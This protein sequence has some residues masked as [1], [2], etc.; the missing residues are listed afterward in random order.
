MVARVW[1]ISREESSRLFQASALVYATQPSS[2]QMGPA[3]FSQQ[4][5]K[6]GHTLRRIGAALRFMAVCG[7]LVGALAGWPTAS[8][9]TE[10]PADSS[11]EHRH[12]GR[13]G[14]D[15]GRAPRRRG[16]DPE[17]GHVGHPR[18]TVHGDG[19]RRPLPILAA[20]PAGKLRHPAADGDERRSGRRVRL[21]SA[22]PA[23]PGRPARSRR[24]ARSAGVHRACGRAGS[25]GPAGTGRPA[26]PRRTSR[27]SRCGRRRNRRRSLS[28]QARTPAM[29]LRLL[30]TVRFSFASQRPQLRVWDQNNRHFPIH[31]HRPGPRHLSG[32]F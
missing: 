23:R 27:S 5:P 1:T 18:W 24:G 11:A 12:Y 9:R 17:P 29:A 4:V 8:H 13:H 32:P 25:G 2:S 20:L 22:G 15:R 7:A 6:P 10:R 14:R 21:R 26:R 19:H 31:L 3:W 16:Q 28:P 30:K